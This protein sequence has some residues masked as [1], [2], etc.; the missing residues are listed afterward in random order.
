MFFLK[1]LLN[2]QFYAYNMA[3]FKLLSDGFYAGCHKFHAKE[4]MLFLLYRT[5]SA[6]LN[7]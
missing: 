7:W 6:F 5:I 4:D 2:C 1:K 3:I